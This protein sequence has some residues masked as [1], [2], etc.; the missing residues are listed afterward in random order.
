MRGKAKGMIVYDCPPRRNIRARPTNPLKS[1]NRKQFASVSPPNVTALE[2]FF[3]ETWPAKHRGKALGLMQSAW[4]IGYA[5]AA[6][7]RPRGLNFFVV[8]TLSDACRRRG[9]PDRYSR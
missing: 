6:L 7:G 9:S 3:A 2:H 8:G 1:P 4:A 5:L